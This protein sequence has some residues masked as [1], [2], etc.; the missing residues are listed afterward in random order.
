MTSPEM[1]KKG[2][3][4]GIVATARKVTEEHVQPAVS[5]FEEW[6][7]NVILSPLLY[8]GLHSYL[9]GTDEQRIASVQR[10]LDDPDVRAVICARGGYGTTRIIDQLDFKEFKKSPKWVVGFSDITSL[11]LKLASLGVESIHGTMPV[12]FSRHDSKE[13]VDQLR[14]TLFGASPEL[15]ANSNKYNK[16][17]KASGVAVG[18]NL[19][20]LVDSLGTSYELETEGKVL[21]IEEV[22]EYLYKLDRMF[23]QLKRSRKLDQLAGLAI[24]HFTDIKDTELSFGESVEEIV[25]FHTKEFTYPIGFGFPT[26]HEN[27][28]YAWIQGRQV[29]LRVDEIGASLMHQSLPNQV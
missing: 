9:A 23:V 11:H 15:H 1:L 8:K 17:G 25:R 2:D 13:S 18:G 14:R 19:S 21:I 5:I 10:F 4:I 3:K 6:G 27:P 24:G 20:L 22:D 26:G 28:N 16:P 29:E 7:L 12:L